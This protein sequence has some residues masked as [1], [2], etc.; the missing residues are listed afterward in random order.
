MI[1]MTRNT[2]IAFH[3][4]Q[5]VDSCVF[6]E[7]RFPTKLYCGRLT[8][9]YLSMCFQSRFHQRTTTHLHPVLTATWTR[10]DSG[11]VACSPQ[12]GMVHCPPTVLGS[13]IPQTGPPPCSI[14]DRREWEGIATIRMSL[15]HT[16][17]NGTSWLLSLVCD[18]ASNAWC[19]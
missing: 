5:R 4:I 3:H 7:F 14:T 11:S 1:W 15:I 8:S 12:T 10:V 9:E 2:T 17:V 6:S 13:P 19:C 16:G 18:W